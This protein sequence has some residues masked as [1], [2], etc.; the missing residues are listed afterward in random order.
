MD[1]ADLTAQRAEFEEA[2]LA[3]ARA[4]KSVATAL[5]AECRYCEEPLW[6]SLDISDTFDRCND[7]IGGVRWE[8]G[9]GLRG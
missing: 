4:A 9:G 1:E 2:Q 6:A 5:F 7:A 8:A 3:K